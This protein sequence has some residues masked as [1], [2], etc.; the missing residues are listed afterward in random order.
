M[1][2]DSSS[3][4]VTILR[5]NYYETCCQTER[6]RRRRSRSVEEAGSAGDPTRGYYSYDLGQWHIVSLNSMCGNVGGC[7]ASSPMVHLAQARPRG[8]PQQVRPI[9]DVLYA[10]DADV[11]VNGRDHDYERFAPRTRAALRI[12]RGG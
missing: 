1:P 5:V 10:A 3:T 4:P 2:G 6:A 9:W 12:R 7:G 11:V 8:P